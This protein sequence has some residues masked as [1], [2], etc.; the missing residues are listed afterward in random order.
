MTNRAKKNAILLS[1]YPGY[2]GDVTNRL[3]DGETT[4]ASDRL[5]IK[6]LILCLKSLNYNVRAISLNKDHVTQKINLLPKAELCFIAKMRAHSLENESLYGLFHTACALHMKKNGAKI[7][8]LYSD[9]LA[10]ENIPDGLLYRNL[11]YLSDHIVT[12]SS[13]LKEHAKKCVCENTKISIVYDLMHLP[14]KPFNELKVGQTC[15]IIWF[16]NNS[17]LHYLY[18]II[19]EIQVNREIE[20]TILGS[21][22]GL[23]FAHEIISKIP[24]HP[25][26]RIRLIP[27][28]DH[29]QP[30]Q[31]EEEL[32]RAHIALLPS[33]PR[34]P[35]KNGVSH[36]RLV[37]A[38]QSGCIVIASPIH[39]YLELSSLSLLGTDFKPLVKKAIRENKR[40]CNKYTKLRTA[41]LKQFNPENNQKS[42]AKVIESL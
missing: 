40:L 28:K 36:N 10:T 17:N 8:T 2:D 6:P 42:W 22:D 13:I 37:D 24:I 1:P 34:D 26:F 35:R 39:S 4:S 23:K 31:L 11:L 33:D 3:L 16:G 14:E 18:P 9:N 27:W 32:D 15:N 19:P 7:I 5:Q 21:A 25:K 30:M 12:P 20:L 29:Q 38:A 41:I